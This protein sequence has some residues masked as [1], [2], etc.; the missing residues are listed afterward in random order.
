MRVIADYNSAT[1]TSCVAASTARGE[2]EDYT[3]TVIA[4]SAC[5]T[6]TAPTALIL[7]TSTTTTQAGSF[8]APT[9]AP[10]GYLVVSSTSSTLTASPVNG[11]TY[12]TGTAFGGDCTIC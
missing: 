4:A 12:T 6:P 11:T 7:G 8:T 5:T 2:A 3:F 1:P 9:T 10:T